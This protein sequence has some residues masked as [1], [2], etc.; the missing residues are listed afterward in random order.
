VELVPSAV[1]PV[2]CWSPLA[3][4]DAQHLARAFRDDGT[5]GEPCRF[6]VIYGWEQ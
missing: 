3:A 4:L 5:I 6:L 2:P 1:A